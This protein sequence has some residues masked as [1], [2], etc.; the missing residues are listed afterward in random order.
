MEFDSAEGIT[1]LMNFWSNELWHEKRRNALA[2]GKPDPGRI[3][4]VFNR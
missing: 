4:L 1:S 3:H 2:S